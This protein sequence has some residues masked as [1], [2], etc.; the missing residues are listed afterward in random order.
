M[1]LDPFIKRI[2]KISFPFLINK[3]SPFY[4]KYF[5]SK[6]AKKIEK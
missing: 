5:F 1:S 2:I 3:N 6:K 4:L